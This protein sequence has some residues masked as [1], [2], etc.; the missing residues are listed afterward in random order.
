MT[1]I[2]LR[3]RWTKI[4]WDIFKLPNNLLIILR[5]LLFFFC[6]RCISNFHYTHPVSFSINVYGWLDLIQFD[7]RRRWLV[8]FLVSNNTTEKPKY[9][10]NDDK[11]LNVLVYTLKLNDWIDIKTIE[12]FYSFVHC[13]RRFTRKYLDFKW[14]IERNGGVQSDIGQ[15]EDVRGFFKV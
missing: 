1:K 6:F 7:R 11:L 15:N 13:Y 3:Q 4:R 10:T 8:G 5:M 14:D 12:L 2:I 9:D